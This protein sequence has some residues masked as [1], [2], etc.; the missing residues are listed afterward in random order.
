MLD[1]KKVASV[2]ECEIIG[3][4]N[5]LEI[6]EGTSSKSGKDRDYISGTATIRV[7][8]EENGRVIENLI[9]I[10]LFS[11]KKKDDGSDNKNYDRIKSYGE[12]FTSIAAAEDISQ[13]TKIYIGGSVASLSEN[14]FVS[15][16]TGKI[17]SSFKISSNF[18]NEARNATTDSAT[19][20][21]TGVVLNLREEMNNQEEP[22][23]RLIVDF[24]VIGYRGR[25]NVL[26]LYAE[27]EGKAFIETSWSSGS[28][29]KVV[30]D[31]RMTQKVVTWTEELG[32]GKPQ[33]KRRTETR[34]EL[35]ITGGSEPLSEDMSYDSDDIK[36]ALAERKTYHDSLI[37]NSKS[38]V[39]S[40]TNTKTGN[41]PFGF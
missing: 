37:T 4:L 15:K 12:K 30:G 25:I 38:L 5:E 3:I 20:T 36:A 28:T 24:G 19:F 13:A 18:L 6:T 7:D 9:P 29:V 16:N 40:K 11:F 34:R 32:F 22:T 39:K 23:G 10:S 35:L 31:I 41:D 1:I 2:N 26:S 33:E 21:L 14:A 27:D 8:T 17:F